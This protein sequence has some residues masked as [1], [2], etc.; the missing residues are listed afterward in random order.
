MD[1]NFIFNPV[2]DDLE[3]SSTLYINE[4]VKRR[5][6]NGETIF[7]MGFGESRF[8]VPEELKVALATHSDKKSYLPAQGLPELTE[9]VANYYS[10]KLDSKFAA[11][12]V[13]VGPGSK[14][15]IY[16]LQMVLGADLFLPTPSWVSYAPQAAILEN[17]CSYITCDAQNEYRL[18][19][20]QLD[21]LVQASSNDSKLLIINTPNNPTGQMMAE[22]ELE[23]LADYC[24]NNKIIVLSDEIY[25]QLTH[26]NKEHI[27]ISRYY[28]EGTIICGGLSKHF[29]IGGWRL[30]VGLLPDTEFGKNL[31]QRMITFAS[32]TWSGVS[33]PI[34]YA[35]IT[36]YSLDNDIEQYVDDCR[37]IH[38]IRTRYCHQ[39]LSKLGIN[40]SRAD[41]A[42]YIAANFSAFGEKLN[43][44]GIITSVKL[45]EHLLSKHKIASLPGSDFGLSPQDLTLRLSTSYLDMETIE[46]SQRI[47]DLY[48]SG[49]T[50]QEFMAKQNHPMTHAAMSAFGDFL[51]FL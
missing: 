32:E 33:S 16:G 29:S 31:M 15:I 6:A 4:Q 41:G 34:Q 11:Q 2:F 17:R 44:N 51:T 1:S 19:L 39:A 48:K 38:S 25:F 18:E 23:E 35:A 36:A 49:L 46:S 5:W 8:N 43:N 21:K 24:R 27:S 20:S 13:I 12:Q 3:P 28:P 14:V 30:G 37:S 9:S 22:G 26:G 47:F 40:C 45:A 7:H 10:N 50:S 42:F